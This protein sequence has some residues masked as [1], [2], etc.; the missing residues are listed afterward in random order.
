MYVVIVGCSESGYHLSKALI[1]G[2][3]EV[4][5]VEN[6]TKRFQLLNE[7]MG[8]VALLGDGTDEVTLKRAG[9]AR[10]DVVVSLTGR[11]QHV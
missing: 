11:L 4:V 8:S 2:G 10:A 3:H 7:E 1:A 9:V 5:V 6:D